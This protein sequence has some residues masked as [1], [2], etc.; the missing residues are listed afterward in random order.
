MDARNLN[1]CHNCTD[2]DLAATRQRVVISR[3]S[4]TARLM[5]IGEAPGAREDALGE[6]FVG[7]SGQL[8]DRL[9]MDAG[10]DLQHDLYICNAVK[11]RPPQNRRPKRSELLAC[12][13]WLDLQIASINP[14]VIVLIG[15]TAVE[16]ILGIKGGMTQ[17]RGQWRSWDGRAVMP[18]FHPSFLLRNPTRA[19]D[20]PTALTCGDL[21]AVQRRLCER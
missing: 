8:L 10:F 19:A 14:E 6:P 1:D 15:A 18:I 12:R 9:L 7:R 13:P 16:A 3:G 5:L 20:G 11:C 17:L 2:C 4:P 21:A